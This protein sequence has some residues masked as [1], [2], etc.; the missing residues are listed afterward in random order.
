MWQEIKK[1]KN[2]S[3]KIINFLSLI[4]KS[5]SHKKLSTL[6]IKHNLVNMD[7]DFWIFLKKIG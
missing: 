2:Q 1:N 5:F 7:S 6:C 3:K 4:E